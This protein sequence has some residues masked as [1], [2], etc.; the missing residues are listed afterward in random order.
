MRIA[1]RRS[2]RG[3]GDPVALGLHADD[4]G[5]GVLGDLADQRLPVLLRHRVAWL[6]PLVGGDERIEVTSDLLAAVL[7]RES[8]V[9]GARL[10]R[11]QRLVRVDDVVAIH[12]S[13]MRDGR[14]SHQ[15][16]LSRTHGAPET[17][18]W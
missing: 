9:V 13:S 4:L 17:M 14:Q 8:L 6:D 1:L 18:L 15:S 11:V 10:R 12:A 7:V 3:A 2:G 5:V 16:G